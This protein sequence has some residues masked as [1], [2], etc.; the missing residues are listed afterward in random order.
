L[1]ERGGK[2]KGGAV[3]WL[4]GGGA[5]MAAGCGWAWGRQFSQLAV[6]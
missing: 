5:A 2:E 1:E 4:R 3:V 6:E